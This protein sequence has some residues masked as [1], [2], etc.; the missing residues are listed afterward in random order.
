MKQ[1]YEYTCQWN[2]DGR[3]I[4]CTCIAHNKT[5]AR[6]QTRSMIVNLGIEFHYLK[7]VGYKRK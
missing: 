3:D 1:Y 7:F 6:L 5:Q 2:A 4:Y